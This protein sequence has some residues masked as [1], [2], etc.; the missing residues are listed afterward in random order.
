M[1]QCLMARQGPHTTRDYGPHGIKPV[2]LYRCVRPGCGLEVWT[3]FDDPAKIR[4]E[5]C[6]GKVSGWE[7][8][9]WV[10][11]IAKRL[12]INPL[13]CRCPMRRRLLNIAGYA[14]QSFFWAMFPFSV[15]R[16]FSQKQDQ[17]TYVHLARLKAADLRQPSRSSCC[18]AGSPKQ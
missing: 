9:E 14:V 13:N 8:G 5:V 11:A 4:S 18:G 16:W 12:G 15:L 6:R 10:A 2:Y 1:T 17:A 7:F 3:P